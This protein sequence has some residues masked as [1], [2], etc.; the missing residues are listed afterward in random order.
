MFSQIIIN[1]GAARVQARSRSAVMLR[2]DD[3]CVGVASSPLRES[4]FQ[5][6]QICNGV[7]GFL[8]EGHETQFPFLPRSTFTKVCT[9]EA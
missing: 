3:P 9:S 5:P 4:D 7:L 1:C 8:T 6:A 2:F